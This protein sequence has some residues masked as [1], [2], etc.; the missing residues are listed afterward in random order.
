MS[1]L[2]ILLLCCRW[3]QKLPADTGSGFCWDDLEE[4]WSNTSKCFGIHYIRKCLKNSQIW[5]PEEGHTI[6][7][8][9]CQRL[10]GPAGR[11]MGLTLS[12]ATLYW[13]GRW[14]LAFLVTSSRIPSCWLVWAGELKFECSK[15][16]HWSGC[17]GGGD[18]ARSLNLSLFS[19]DREA[20]DFP[21]QVQPH[22]Y[23]WK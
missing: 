2:I 9:T 22:I 8:Y 4:A 10:S 18:T 16:R 15:I 7:S 1:W 6:H 23:P 14:G 13:P 3:C 11:I 5:L 20:W 12:Q 17:R 19:E 21:C